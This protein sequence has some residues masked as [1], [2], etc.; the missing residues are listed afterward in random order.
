MR[1]YPFYF[2][3]IVGLLFLTFNSAQ[4]YKGTAVSLGAGK[5]LR[6]DLPLKAEKNYQISINL[7]S[8]LE[9]AVIAATL[10]SRLENDEIQ[11][12][13]TVI[14]DLGKEGQWQNLSLEIDTPSSDLRWELVITANRKGLYWWDGL[15]VSGK[16]SKKQSRLPDAKKQ[17]AFYTGLVVDAKGLPLEKGMSPRIYSQSGQLIYGGVLA[18]RDLVQEQGVVS[19]GRDLTPEL[20]QRLRVSQD[21]SYVFPL[22]IKAAGVVEPGRTGVYISEEDAQKILEAMVR[23]DFL[24]RYAVIILLD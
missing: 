7:R 6:L 21:D 4:A 10:R 11:D 23:Y 2:L 13:K 16:E 8:Y 18:P 1:R 5:E 20:L 17:D 15:V 24:A 3:V 12:H 14:R 22:I 9:E 19:Y